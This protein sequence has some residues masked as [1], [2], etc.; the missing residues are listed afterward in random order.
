MACGCCGVAYADPVSP[1]QVS[2]AVAA[3]TGTV[4]KSAVETSPGTAA[5]AFNQPSTTTYSAQPSSSPQPTLVD[6]ATTS[7]DRPTE[8]Q[9]PATAILQV[10]LAED[11]GYHKVS[12]AD[13]KKKNRETTAQR[14][15]S[16]HLSFSRFRISDKNK[17]KKLVFRT[18]RDRY[19]FMYPT[20]TYLYIYICIITYTR[21]ILWIPSIMFPSTFGGALSI[22][23]NRCT[24]FGF[25]SQSLSLRTH[26]G[27]I[28]LCANG[29]K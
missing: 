29:R 12:V 5:Y 14:V 28:F 24:D 18:H 17:N 6:A 13:K 7:A 22:T 16:L 27:K 8:S 23:R 11:G 26:T 19:M 1:A 10:P 9:T 20:R 3:A 4:E 2:A 25:P 15:V 21:I